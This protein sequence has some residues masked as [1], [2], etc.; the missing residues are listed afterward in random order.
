MR[1]GPGTDDQFKRTPMAWT[2]GTAGGFSTHDP[3]FRFAP[4]RERANV[5]TERT[6]PASLLRRYIALIRL[7]HATPALMRGATTL[8]SSADT[9]TSILAFVR[10]EGAGRVLVAHNLGDRPAVAGPFAVEGRAFR[11]IFADR[12]MGAPG[13][14][15]RGV[16]IRIPPHATG[17]WSI[18]QKR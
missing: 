12:G 5:A 18:E 11:P 15:T 6:D 3:W 9:A 13:R 17:V 10:G 8:L 16:T 1:N 2:A 14:T 7:R 4:G